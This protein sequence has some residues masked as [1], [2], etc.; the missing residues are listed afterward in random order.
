[1]HFYEAIKKLLSEQGMDSLK[2]V[3]FVDTLEL[4]NQPAVK[5]VLRNMVSMGYVDQLVQMG[6]MDHARCFSL[7]QKFV[8]ETGFQELLAVKVA[9]GIAYGL[10]W[11]S[12]DDMLAKVAMASSQNDANVKYCVVVKSFGRAKELEVLRTV[13]E[14]MDKDMM[15]TAA[16]LAQ[17]PLVVKD[18]VSN[19]EAEDLKASLEKAGAV[20]GIEKGFAAAQTAK[21]KVDLGLSVKWATC[22]VGANAPEDS[23]TF[24]SWGETE[25]KEVFDGDNC[26]THLKNIADFSG[27]PEHDA[28]TAHWGKEWRTPTDKECQELLDNCKWEWGIY[29]STNNDE[30][31][32]E[33]NVS[34][35]AADGVQGYKVTGPN[36]NSIFLPAAGRIATSR[37]HGPSGAVSGPQGR[38][39]SSSPVMGGNRFASY[40]NFDKESH[41][42]RYYLR[43]FGRSVRPVT[44]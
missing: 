1:M 29:K 34:D 25:T 18:G 7:V 2:N 6:S 26:S 38:Y 22:N 44:D 43:Y 15:E 31:V 14:V 40:I 35:D 4:D 33:K 23:G 11:I 32:I 9:L 28:A 5:F 37:T 3:S 30:V 27:N 12:E 36:G 10:G 19:A 39:W 41:D 13:M 16:L 8:T 42:I 24:F 17:L 21:R 20:V